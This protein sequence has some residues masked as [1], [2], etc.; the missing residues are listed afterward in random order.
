[1]TGPRSLLAAIALSAACAHAPPAHRAGDERLTGVDFEGNHQLSHKVLLTGL[2]LHRTMDRGGAPDPYMVQVDADRIRGQY[3][4]KGFLDVGVSSRVERKGDSAR[5]IYTVEEGPRATT[6]TVITGLPDDLPVDK[7]RA[8]LPLQDGK[9]FEYEA[10]DLARP[11][12]LGVV[13]D[14]GYAHARLDASVVADRAEHTAVVELAYAAGPKCRFGNVEIAGATGDLAEA[15]RDRLAFSPGQQYSAQAIIQTQRN[16]YGFGRFSTVR[17][18]PDKASGGEVV[19]VHVSVA[20]GSR[21]EVTLGGGFGL[22]QLG[23]EV[24]GRAGYVIKGWP[25]PLDTVTFDLRPA[26]GQRDGGTWEPRIRAITKFE[27]EDLFWTYA[28][29]SIEAGYKYLTVEA[30]TSYGP[31]ARLGFQTRLGSPRVL[32][33]LGWRLEQISYTNINGEL[34]MPTDVADQGLAAHLRIDRNERIGGYQQALVVDLRDHPLE[35]TLGAYGEVQAF[36]GTPVGGGAS[37]FLSILPDVRGYVPLVLG[38]VLAAHARYGAIFGDVPATERFFS[39]GASSQRGFSERRLSPSV[40]SMPSMGK[41]AVPYGGAGLVDTGLE[42][43]VPVTTVRNMPLGFAVFLDG[44]DVTDRAPDL[45]FTNLHWAVG[46]G[47]RLQTAVGPARLD[48]GYRLNRTELGEPD[49]GSHFAYHL[50][51]GEAF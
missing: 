39:G 13:Q 46:T 40:P 43:R 35:P 19:G 11:Q 26:Y 8:K 50:S 37:N 4:R 21:H 34:V 29:G 27:R 10:F 9:P 16:L 17:V 38:A 31:L 3:L 14:A 48:V 6:R 28:K 47:L 5:V 36:E 24:R 51:I 32:L 33:R 12:L 30:Y 18:E 23:F 22:D 25:F 45:D 49:A 20:E 44:G 41:R 2:G 1:M 42:A 7:V 15:V